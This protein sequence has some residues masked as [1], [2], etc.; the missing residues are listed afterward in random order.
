MVRMEDLGRLGSVDWLRWSQEP[1]CQLAC[2]V[3]P[4]R[5]WMPVWYVMSAP[6]TSMISVQQ[7]LDLVSGLEGL[8][9]ILLRSP[10]RLPFCLCSPTP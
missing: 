7:W 6:S 5:K 8:F 9:F 2:S 4:C 3:S 10:L 1:A